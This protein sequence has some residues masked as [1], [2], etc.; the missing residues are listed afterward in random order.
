MANI[1]LFVIVNIDEHS[2]VYFV[3]VKINHIFRAP[4][5]SPVNVDVRM[6]QESNRRSDQ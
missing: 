6:S 3:F 5:S 1:S 4:S 2:P